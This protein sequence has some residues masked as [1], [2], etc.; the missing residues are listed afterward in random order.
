MTA[1]I[2][3]SFASVLEENMDEALREFLR[4]DFRS[5]RVGTISFVMFGSDGAAFPS[6]G[7]TPA[8]A[9]DRHTQS[10]SH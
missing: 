9:D 6:I 10:H 8:Q 3:I 5:R 2:M 1:S 7:S 4:D